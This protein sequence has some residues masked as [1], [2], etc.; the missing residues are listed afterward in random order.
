MTSLGRIAVIWT[1]DC[2]HL[3]NCVFR[4]AQE[5]DTYDGGMCKKDFLKSNTCLH[6]ETIH[7]LSS[8]RSN[9]MA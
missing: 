7:I 6:R 9:E 4:I 8:L 5:T 2:L 1:W 3:Q